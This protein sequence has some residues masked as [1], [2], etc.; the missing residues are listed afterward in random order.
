MKLHRL[1]TVE[2]SERPLRC[3]GRSSRA[4][5][6]FRLPQHRSPRPRPPPAGH[7]WLIA[8]CASIEGSR[9]PQNPIY[10][11]ISF[12][13]WRSI[14]FIFMFFILEWS[15]NVEGNP[16]SGYPSVSPPLVVRCDLTRG[17]TLG[18][19]IFWMLPS[20]NTMKTQWNS[21]KSN[22]NS[23]IFNENQMKFNELSWKSNEIQWNSMKFNENPMKCIRFEPLAEALIQW[24]LMHIHGNLSLLS[25]WLRLLLM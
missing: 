10:N 4:F 21:T 25:P 22:D 13:F 12:I 23:I 14:F 18:Q 6:F 2:R 19:A 5:D 17:E 24:N 16:I 20:E 7:G 9:V 8:S 15:S 1:S 3:G 11:M